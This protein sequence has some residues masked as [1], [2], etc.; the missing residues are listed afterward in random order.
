MPPAVGAVCCRKAKAGLGVH[1]GV[2][3]IRTR[4]SPLQRL[5]LDSSLKTTWLHSAAVQFPLARHHSELRHRLVDVMCSTRNGRCDPK[6]P[7]ASRLRMIR[8]DTGTLVK[9]LPVP[10]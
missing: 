1:H 3:H 5:N 9:V 7:S 10:R 2:L 8:E 6:C 4:L